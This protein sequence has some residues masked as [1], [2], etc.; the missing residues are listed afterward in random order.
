V[1]RPILSFRWWLSSTS[2][3]ARVAGRLCLRFADEFWKVQAE[4]R[5]SHIV[6]ITLSSLVKHR[7]FRWRQAS[8]GLDERFSRL[9]EEASP[10]LFP[11][12]DD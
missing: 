12:M 3:W 1:G 4:L 7:D 10:V 5:S 9:R 11:V 6:Q 2:D 8:Q